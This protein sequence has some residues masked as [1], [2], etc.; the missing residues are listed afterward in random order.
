MD[1][2]FFACKKLE[3]TVG[4]KRVKRHYVFYEFD[5]VLF[6]SVQSDRLSAFA[7]RFTN[8]EL[9]E[10]AAACIED[11]DEE[12]EQEE[13]GED[14]EEVDKEDEEGDNEEEEVEEE[15]EDDDDCEIG[16]Q[17]SEDE[18]LSDSEDSSEETTE[19]D[20][21]E[22][23]LNRLESVHEEDSAEVLGRSNAPFLVYTDLAGT[24][25]I[26]AN[27]NCTVSVNGEP[28]E[29]EESDQT[30]NCW[31]VEE[32]PESLTIKFSAS[33]SAI[34]G[35]SKLVLKK[36]NLTDSTGMELL[37]LLQPSSRK[38]REL[39]EQLSS[40]GTLSQVCWQVSW[41]EIGRAL[42]TGK[43]LHSP[44]FSPLPIDG[45]HPQLRA[46]IAT[47]KDKIGVK[48]VAWES[49][50]KDTLM[51]GM[52]V[53][54]E[55]S[56]EAGLVAPLRRLQGQVKDVQMREVP[57]TELGEED[58]NACLRSFLKDGILPLLFRRAFNNK[59]IFR[60]DIFLLS[61]LTC[62]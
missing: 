37:A 48:K 41:S 56:P 5:R 46:I 58:S 10:L 22:V 18:V 51:A 49:R 3:N 21:T 57:W 13:E 45:S 1:G 40:C 43:D 8:K 50:G 6:L 53:W 35:Q 20:N 55:G 16:R 9:A 44:L 39:A 54:R 12:E 11:G 24:V 17:E 60:V 34:E 62:S 36:L 47:S 23:D 42:A 2:G 19:E 59:V 30:Q 15:E 7:L 28:L 27:M 26:K 32:P 31:K 14:P 38:M 25:F 61:S 52:F 4:V 29:E 33:Q